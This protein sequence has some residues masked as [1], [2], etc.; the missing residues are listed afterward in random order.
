MTLIS[1]KIK[2]LSI[3]I[4]LTF[5][6]NGCATVVSKEQAFPKMYE[7][8]PISILVVPAVNNTTAAEAPEYFA[9]TVAEPLSRMGYYVL[10]IEVTTRMIREQGVV[11]GAQLSNVDVGLFKTMYGADA[12]M[13]VDINQWDTSYYVIGGNVSVGMA[14]KLVSTSS[15]EV[16]WQYSDVIVINTGGDSGGGLIGALISTAINTAMTDYVPIAKQVNSA[17]LAT[18]P[19]GNY[20]PKA[21]VDRAAQAVNKD[22]AGVQN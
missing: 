11:D 5:V 19:F 3:L 17:A 2:F 6:L 21:G 14:Y 10:P 7:A 9:T 16:L 20:H 4:A 22:K 12:V 18:M 8:N 13:Y 1:N 15:K